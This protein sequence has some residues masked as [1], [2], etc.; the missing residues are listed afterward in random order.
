MKAVEKFGL[1]E[2][3]VA[4]IR[5]QTGG[6]Y[7]YINALQSG[8]EERLRSGLE[9]LSKLGNETMFALE[10]A[11]AEAMVGGKLHTLAGRRQLTLEALQHSRQVRSGLNKLP[12]APP[13]TAVR[14]TKV[15][16]AEFQSDYQKG[17]I[18]TPSNYPTSASFDRVQALG[19]ATKTPRKGMVHVLLTMHITRGKDLGDIS[20]YKEKEI[21]ILPGSRFQVTK[22][23]ELLHVSGV[24]VWQ[25][26]MRQIDD[27]GSSS[28]SSAASSNSSMNPASSTSTT[29]TSTITSPSVVSLLPTD[30][31]TALSTDPAEVASPGSSSSMATSRSSNSSM[32]TTATTTMSADSTSVAST[33]TSSST[34]TVAPARARASPASSLPVFKLKLDL[35]NIERKT[36]IQLVGIDTDGMASI[37]RMGSHDQPTRVGVKALQ[38][39]IYPQL[40][41]G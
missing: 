8:G 34:S 5:V 19:Y 13:T 15:P 16:L 12:Y 33:S 41:P 9:K 14:G 20:L 35:G 2:D 27:A 18:P 4:A 31:T 11:R 25:V 22:D 37:Q 21:I 17:G 38:Q 6:D 32:N 30:P 7:T 39:A 23:P 10:E 26:E 3:E 1:T 40:L 28:A 24:D 36:W 29:S